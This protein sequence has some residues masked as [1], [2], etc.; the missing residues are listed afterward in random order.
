MREV[1]AAAVRMQLVADVPLGIFLS[2]GVDSSAVAAMAAEVAPTRY[3]PLL[4]GSMFRRSTKRVSPS[5]WPGDR[6]PAH[7]RRPQRAAFHEQLPRAFSAIDQP[8]FDG[9][10]TYFVSRAA[11]DAGMTVALAGH[12]R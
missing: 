12:R 10:N 8:T 6:E 5:G 11:R 4:L 2:G 1:L 7:D 3:T 9:I